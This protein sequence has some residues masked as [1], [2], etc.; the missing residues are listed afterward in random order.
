M[1]Q[2]KRAVRRGKTD[3]AVS[4]QSEPRFPY[5]NKPG[6]LR[7]LLKEIPRKP[8]PQKFDR[9][10]LQSWGFRDN[11]DYTV[12]RVLKAVN[13]LTD[14]SEPTDIYIRFMELDS[15]AKVLAP[16]IR[17]IYAPLF[18][19][20][21]KPYE[22]SSE[23]LKNLFNIYSGGGDRTLELQIQTFKA[24]CENADFS[25]V[26]TAGDGAIAGASPRTPLDPSLKL[27]G[28]AGGPIIN[29][30]LHIHLPENKSRRDYEDIIEDIGKYIFGRATEGG[31][32]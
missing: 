32:D 20:S 31:R 18:E 24:L 4:D 29:I 6:S 16:E 8:R 11:N 14:T 25:G 22:E 26:A 28:G 15:G 19:A 2:K 12:V 7:R 23:R 3:T 27:S 1:A 30:N 21:Q 17:R 10:L 13:L 9:R 5:T